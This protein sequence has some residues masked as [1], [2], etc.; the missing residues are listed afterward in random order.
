[1]VGHDWC[2]APK[3]ALDVMSDV[4]PGSL[5]GALCLGH[6][7]MG[8]EIL[9]AEDH[10]D[11]Q[12]EADG[13]DEGESGGAAHAHAR[14]DEAASE[15]HLVDDLGQAAVE[16][17]E[18]DIGA[19]EKPAGDE[20]SGEAEQG[21]SGHAADLLGREFGGFGQAGEMGWGLKR[22]GDRGWGRDQI[23]DVIVVCFGEEKAAGPGGSVM[24]VGVRQVEGPH[25]DVGIGGGF[26]AVVRSSGAG[27]LGDA[28]VADGCKEEEHPEE[29]A[30]EAEFGGADHD[31]VV[32]GDVE[33]FAEALEPDAEDGV[34]ADELEAGGPGFEA[35][36]AGFDGDFAAAGPADGHGAGKGDG[37]SDK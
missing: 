28:E 7:L 33:V 16:E 2:L 18:H 13:A 29:E 8:D 25:A 20:E 23:V 22:G 3:V 21:E 34:R 14:W 11:D 35:V 24:C 19:R 1:M 15:G 5:V 17:E 10:V 36:R 31:R 37:G 30:E 27:L 12:D 6:S 4:A 32:G 26:V 9:Q